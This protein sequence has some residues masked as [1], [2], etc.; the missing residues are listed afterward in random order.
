MVET[1]KTLGV[2]AAIVKLSPLI[3]HK[4]SLSFLLVPSIFILGQSLRHSIVQIHMD[5]IIHDKK[6]LAKLFIICKLKY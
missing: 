4:V 1:L 6:F 2:Y 5:A 3:L